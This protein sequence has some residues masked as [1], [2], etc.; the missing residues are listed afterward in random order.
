MSRSFKHT[1]GFTDQQ[2][3]GSGAYK[4]Q[5]NKK[6]RCDEAL[7]NGSTFKRNGLSWDICE[8]KFLCFNRAERES[9]DLFEEN[10]EYR[11]WIK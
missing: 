8:N 9:W 4:R 5:S 7:P 10:R 6:T 3:G 2:R 1:P 11:M